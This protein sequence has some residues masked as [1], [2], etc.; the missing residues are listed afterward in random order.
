[1][2]K[3]IL[4]RSTVTLSAAA[5]PWARLPHP[6][7]RGVIEIRLFRSAL[8]AHGGLAELLSSCPPVGL[9]TSL[10][11]AKDDTAF[12]LGLVQTICEANKL[13][14]DWEI[15]GREKRS[16]LPAANTAAAGTG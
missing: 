11:S 4:P 12:R 13:L 16:R 15:Q 7:L 6:L 10:S 8:V 3:P 2:H 5:S 9:T 14:D 1:M